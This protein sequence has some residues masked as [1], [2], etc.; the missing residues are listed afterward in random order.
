MSTFTIS[1]QWTKLFNQIK[2]LKSQGIDVKDLEDVLKSIPKK[3]AKPAE[4]QAPAPE[5]RARKPTEITLLGKTYK[6]GKNEEYKTIL[7]LSKKLKVDVKDLREYK[8]DSGERTIIKPSGQT[9]EINIKSKKP[10]L[11]REF[12]IK[13]ITNQDLIKTVNTIKREGQQLK[14]FKNIPDNT[15]I[16]VNISGTI[17]VLFSPPT[18][19]PVNINFTKII[20]SGSDIN[21]V[22]VNHATTSLFPFLEGRDSI[23]VNSETIRVNR[24]NEGGQLMKLQDMILRD[25]K[26]PSISNMYSN[27]IEDTNWEHC[28][29]D[30]MNEIYGKRY[31]KKTIDKL[32]T[33]ND[34]YNFCV[35]KNIKMIAYDINGKCIMSNYPKIKNG[36]KNM[37]FIAY[38]NHLYPLKN[39]YLNKVIVNPNTIEIIEN[40]ESKIIEIL[41]QG[42]YVSNVNLIGSKIISFIDRNIKYI[43]NNEYM[44][45]KDILSKFG[46]EDKIYDS[47]SLI[48][49]GK[50]IKDLYITKCDKS[51]FINHEKFVKGGFNYN[52][53]D[54]KGDYV[55]YDY[56]KAYPSI[57][58]KLPFLITC[59]MISDDICNDIELDEDY[60]LYIVKP[61]KSSILLPDTNCYSGSH[62]KYCKNEGL[63]F[64]ILEKLSCNRLDNH[65]TLM[66]NDLYKKVDNKTFKMIM[67]PL[68]GQMENSNEKIY[69]N[70]IKFCNDDELKTTEEEHYKVEINEN[71]NMI[72]E[73]KNKINIYNRKPIAIQIKDECRKIMYQLMKKLNLEDGNIKSINTDCIMY[74]GKNTLKK[75][76]NEIG[77]W[78]KIDYKDITS[79]FNFSNENLSFKTKSDNICMM[80]S[81]FGLKTKTEN[82][83]L[84]TNDI[85]FKNNSINNNVF[86]NCYAG[87]GKSYK[88]INDYIPNMNND[89]I[90][91]TPSHASVKEYKNLKL[92]GDV[93]Q[94]YEYKFE[95]PNVNN[96]IIDEMGMC[97]RKALT[98]LLQWALNG[99]RIIAY[100]DFKQLLP[101]NEYKPL[102][103]SIFQN[104]VFGE[105]DI[106]DVNRRNNFNKE[107]YDAIINGKC[108]NKKM[109][110]KYN[111]I[112][113]NN[114]ICYTNKT[115]MKYNDIIM[116]KLG[117]ENI[118]SIG[119]KVISNSNDLRELEI[120][121]K[122]QFTV[123]GIEDNFIILD[124]EHKISRLCYAMYFEPAYARTIYSIQGESM[125]DFY[126]PMDDE[127]YLNDRTTY[128]IISRLKG[129]NFCNKIILK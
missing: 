114:I 106:M 86:G 126:F 19:Q 127:R 18:Y 101:I 15:P 4:I 20:K 58:S 33:T 35:D 84:K 23:I 96:I 111:N 92:N 25:E 7:Q 62:L 52:N 119:C 112:N 94:K 79:S 36:R 14:I 13:R 57:L 118:E 121:N 9:I 120:Y 61:D 32:N 26:P 69:N 60:Y 28:I 47:I 129:M 49:I 67:N 11:L 89:Y 68:I 38:N 5:T 93:I 16:K 117:I 108:D 95:M 56:S 1:P 37:I 12:G 100:G 115:C 80:E 123:T 2:T 76:S 75:T 125:N 113:S 74:V 82:L 34:I 64:T 77:C 73:I 24:N 44:K 50:T 104:F 88:I 46:L 99:K 3:I 103:S 128:T 45:C 55:C 40:S 81:Y 124:N 90:V 65:Y 107:F 63:K 98:V 122:F 97:S 105:E 17:Q 10:L 71:L 29:H 66:I 30:Y 70:F 22:I 43:N 87:A 42:R 116:K 39:N 53:P 85:S 21:D 78:K 54:V 109:I 59:N 91:L 83:S 102:M 27:I 72:Y 41:E 48:T 6:I 110:N 31:C 51:L 8:K